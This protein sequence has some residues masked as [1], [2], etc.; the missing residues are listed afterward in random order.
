MTQVDFYVGTPNPFDVVAQ[1]CQKALER[2]WKVRILTATTQESLA[3]DQHLWQH[4]PLSFIP[5]CRLGDALQDQ[6]PVLIG[7]DLTHTGSADMLI[8]L[9]PEVPP[10]FAQFL[11][12]A[13]I[14]THHEDAKNSGRERYRFYQQRGYP[15]NV[16]SLDKARKNS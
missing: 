10:F 11:R 6:T 13:E 8:N 15:L 7:E 2:K 12:L 3:L 16:H 9:H 14:V 4:S 1:L 5:H